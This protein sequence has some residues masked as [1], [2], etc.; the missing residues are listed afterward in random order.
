MT[1]RIIDGFDYLPSSGISAVMQ[2]QGWFGNTSTVVRDSAT[3]FGYGYSM[4]LSSNNNNDSL[5]RYMRNRYTGECVI[6]MRM[7]IPS[8]GPGY[9]LSA[10]DSMTNGEQRQWRLHL[11]ENGNID[12]ITGNNTIVS[13]TGAGQYVPEKWFYLEIKWT[14]HLTTG[15]FELRIN[16]VPVLS[17][18]SVQTAYGTLVGV[19]TR[20]WDTFEWWKSSISGATNNWRWDDLYL[21]DDAGTVNNDYLGNV[22][23]QYMAP[24]SDDVVQWI[25]GGTAPAATNWE[26]VLNT[27]LDDTKYVYES[28]VNDR[29]LYNINPVLN[30]PQVFGVEINASYR[31]D[32][33]TQR[34]VSNSIKTASGVS[35]YGTSHAIN[36][37]Y[38]FYS[39]IFE[40]NP[41]TGVAF[42]G[43]EVNTLKIGPR[44]DV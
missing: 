36:Q 7:K 40:L 38:T 31:Q 35:S 28:T 44:V 21:L 5:Q 25:I 13:R 1:L 26:S 37:S 27:A 39:D 18:P 34:F 16:T 12:Y 41:D 19:G 33:A 23:A 22:R 3:A 8:V 32:D 14:P 11:M 17:L 30:T 20:G 10:I 24:V 6:G 43:A 2:A 9:S 4:G 29:D 42:T 15:S